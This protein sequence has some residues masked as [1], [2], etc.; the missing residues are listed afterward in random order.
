M[1]LH[2]LTQVTAEDDRDG[3]RERERGK[4]EARVGVHKARESQSRWP[5]KI[6]Y[7]LPER[8][9]HIAKH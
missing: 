2:S 9:G 7:H 8:F 5:E 1:S 3:E 4:K 6:K